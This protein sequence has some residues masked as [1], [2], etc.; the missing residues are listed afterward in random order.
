MIRTTIERIAAEQGLTAYFREVAGKHGDGTMYTYVC[1][2]QKGNTR[3]TLRSLGSLR[4]IA[5]LSEADLVA[6][7]K[8]K[9]AQ[10]AAQKDKE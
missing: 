8:T 1:V 10:G 4:S 7:M 6:L 9:I 5:Q 2:A 3:E